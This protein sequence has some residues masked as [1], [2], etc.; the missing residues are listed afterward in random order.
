MEDGKDW[1]L[2]ASITT[3]T[4]DVED[5]L[6]SLTVD[7]NNLN[8]DI[9]PWFRANAQN[10]QAARFVNAWTEWRN[11]T[12]KFIKSWKEGGFFKIKLAWNYADNADAR[13]RELSEWRRRWE[14]LS[15]EKSTAP[16]SIATPPKK[17]PGESG[18]S[19]WK[20]AAALAAGGLG[21]MFVAKKLGSS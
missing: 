16:A 15:G 5:R 7:T 10:V 20:W 12:Y 9:T 21:A 13:I 1:S 11:G 19:A 14:Q 4:D 17:A 3:S 18:G 2:G 6:R 8:A